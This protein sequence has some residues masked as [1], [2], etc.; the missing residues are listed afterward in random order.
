MLKI[1]ALKN[2][3]S[4]RE[5][6]VGFWLFVLLLYALSKKDV[7]KSLLDVIR[8][9]F[10]KKFIGW[11]ISMLLYV[12]SI[13]FIL[14]KIGFWEFRLL[15]DT[16]IWYISVAIVNSIKSIGEAK[17][18]KYFENIIK[19]NVKIVII[20]EFIINLYNFSLICEI[21]LIPVI[22][23]L[24]LFKMSFELKTKYQNENYKSIIKL[25]NI[26][27]AV[28]GIYILFYSTIKF[29]SDIKNIVFLDLFKDL[30]LP[31]ILSI[32]FVPYVY[33]FVLYSTYEKVFIILKYKKTIDDKY[34]FLLYFRIILFCKFN[35]VKVNNFINYSK[36]M[37]NYIKSKDDINLLFKN[38]KT[39]VITYNVDK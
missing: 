6:A 12:S 31:S 8:I 10:S 30:I 11:H 5:L 24:Y 1:L 23:F 9:F 38:Y 29:L 37:Y 15:K 20:L 28:I 14:F 16:I 39:N 21:I 18:M 35:I 33:L 36:I 22:S 17:D 3:F 27:T 4:N 26:I 32:M 13:I 25:L 34:R 7:R 2:I 19:D